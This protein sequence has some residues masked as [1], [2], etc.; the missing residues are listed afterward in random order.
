MS[1][2]AAPAPELTVETLDFETLLTLILDDAQMIAA[3]SEDLAVELRKNP[4]ALKRTDF[5]F[6]RFKMQRMIDYLLA[7]AARQ[8]EV[9]E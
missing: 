2:T 7:Y 3:F 5:N 9:P 1:A 4:T 8:E 6:V